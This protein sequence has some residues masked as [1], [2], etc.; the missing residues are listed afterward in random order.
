MMKTAALLF[1][2]NNANNIG[3][4]LA[5]HIALGF[6]TLIICDDHSTDGTWDILLNAKPF[7]DLRLFR[8]N[9]NIENITERQLFFQKEAVETGKNEFDW[10][11]FLASDEYLDFSNDLTLETFLEPHKE[12]NIIPINWCLFGSNG[13]IT[14]SPL[15]PIETFTYHAPLEHHDH[16]IA[17]YFINPTVQN[18]P[19]FPDPFTH[20]DQPADWSH[21][22]ILHF[23]AGDKT[24]F[25]QHCTDAAPAEAWKHFD[26]NDIHDV[27][28]HRWLKTARNVGA[29]IT[30]A[31]LA[32]LYWRLHQI[33]K[34]QDENALHALG[35]SPLIF[36]DDGPN[37]APPSFQFFS[38]ET[39]Y[40]LLWDANKNELISPNITSDTPSNSHKLI[41]ALE[42]NSPSPHFSIIL[43][44]DIIPSTYIH[45]DQ[46][47][48]LLNI[49][50]VKVLVK[51][52]EIICAITGKNI[53]F[54]N[55]DI[56]FHVLNTSDDLSNRLTPF[57][58]FIQGGHTLSSL[59]RGIERSL[60]PNATALGYAIATLPQEDLK[61]LTALFPG[62]IPVGLQP[63]YSISDKADS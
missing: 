6:S 47:P 41:L 46:I 52:Q 9:P 55:N 44:K 13:Q 39:P 16:R 4:W 18:T 31:N 38:L 23:A 22:R 43:S 26:R 29:T 35:L 3:W 15:S 11:I 17:R 24:S 28:P 19:P 33:S 51:E 34:D 12:N 5:H 45:F 36:N 25:F 10:M 40:D 2:R 58:P 57:I 61:R 49:I 59:L 14:P 21:A 37:T 7:Y 1:V 54:N 62:L 20:I 42:N 32:D 30:Q 48:S 27:T 8:S 63:A 50:P 53:Q 56:I 60:A